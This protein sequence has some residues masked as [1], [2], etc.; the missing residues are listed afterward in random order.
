MSEII[1][2]KTVQNNIRAITTLE[3][4]EMLNMKHYKVLEKLEGTK[5]GK[6]KGIINILAHHDFVVSDYFIQSTYYDTSGKEN[7]CYLVT[8]LG[9]DFLANKFTGEKGVLFTARYVKRF[10]E[11]EQAL[12]NP[13]ILPTT[14]TEAL[15]QLL[16]QVKEKERLALE[17]EE[18]KPKAEYCNT[19]LKK[20]DLITTTVIAKD[21]GITARM[22]NKVMNANGIIY[23][24]PF[25]SWCPYAKYQWLITE[26]YAD[27]QSYEKEN[28]KLCL[29]W[30][31]K[32]RKWI[33]DNYNNWV[34]NMF[35]A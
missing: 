5:D 16:A 25:G 8:K 9:C 4:A 35:A 2:F 1:N 27:Y 26:G 32:G 17:N 12:K 28:T 23:K 19:V 21:L 18:L 34:A 3:I 33:M 14:Y 20:P 22:L 29:K 10:D 24:G 30:T 31:E 13:Y 11:M 6:T 15:E 7:K